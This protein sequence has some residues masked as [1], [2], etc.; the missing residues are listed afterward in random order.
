M[1][2]IKTVSLSK[3][4]RQLFLLGVF[5]I[6]MIGFVRPKLI[7]LN[8][9]ELSVRIRLRRRTWNHLG[10]MYFGALAV[11]AD[12]AAG[13]HAFYFSEL[14]GYKTSLAFKGIR[15]EFI[16]RAESDVIFRCTEGQKILEVL[17]K[18]KAEGDRV[19][20]PVEVKAYNSENEEV[21]T[22]ELILSLRVKS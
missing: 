16:K 12:L 9:E 3:I 17:E 19:N 11:G 10:S 15:G 6:P 2:T 5:K 7:S 21:A 20:V 1:S 18:S 13:L 22:F 8:D 14:K 4:R